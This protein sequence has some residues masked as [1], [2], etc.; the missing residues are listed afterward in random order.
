MSQPR[1]RFAQATLIAALGLAAGQSLQ[2]ATHRIDDSATQVLSSSVRMRTDTRL[3]PRNG[4]PMTWTG[5]V[6]VRVRLDLAPWQGRNGKIYM[7]LPNTTGTPLTVTWASRG[8]LLPGV[9]RS[10]ERTLVHAGPVPTGVGL[11]EETLQLR[12]DSDG[13]GLERPQQLQFG[14]EIDMESP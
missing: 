3:L 6:D 13:R 4:E 1:A 8:R 5:T 14:F 2:A 9:L 10:G 11:F 12:I 7:T